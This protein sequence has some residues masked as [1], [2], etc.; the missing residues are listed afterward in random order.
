M[1]SELDRKVGKILAATSNIPPSKI[2]ELLKT[3]PEANASKS[4]TDVLVEQKLLGRDE[5]A[6]LADS[7]SDLLDAPEIPGFELLA[8]LGQGG[9]GAVY[10]AKQI[11]MGRVVALKILPEHL[12]RDPLFVERFRR[13]AQSSAKLDHPNVVRGIDVGESN[14]VHYF[15]MEFV[16]G[17]SVQDILDERGKLSVADALRIAHDVAVALVHAQEHHMVHRDIKPD[18]IMVTSKG[19]VKLA[20]LGL[21]KQTDEQSAMTQTGSGFGTPYYMS[22]EQARNAK[23]VDGRSDIYALGASLFRMITGKVPYEGETAMEVLLSKEKGLA[24]KASAL[25][26]DV[27]K[28]INPLLDKMMAKDP[29]RRHQKAEELVA[30]IE[31]LGLM[32]EVLSF[33]PGAAVRSTP[34]PRAASSA[35]KATAPNSGDRTVKGKSDADHDP[36]LWY[37]RYRDSS[38]RQVKTKA[39]TQRVKNMLLEG[40]LDETVEASHSPG[41]PFRRLQGYP[42]FE[43]LLR[44]RLARSTADKKVAKTASKMA[45]LITNIDDEQAAHKRKQYWR[46]VGFKFASFLF[47]LLLVGGGGWAIWTYIVTPYSA[48]QS[49]ENLRMQQEIQREKERMGRNNP[50]PTVE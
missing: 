1:A 41:G 42:E 30:D 38:G 23:Y 18:N 16:D 17:K 14:G 15:A 45:D 46:G 32:A 19:V 33:L 9:M 24:P 36:N 22:P 8:K 40:Q 29:A 39:H 3:I 31:R 21:A 48:R 49:A 27:P 20:D 50:R 35:K 7:A 11:S 5:A 47:A 4:L 25:N 12:A 43:P 34:A 37:L 2:D 28:A 26:P 6:R 44:S 10:K 13:E